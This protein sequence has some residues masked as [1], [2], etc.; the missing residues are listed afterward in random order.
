MKQFS[1]LATVV[2]LMGL[3]AGTR[4]VQAG[5]ITYSF[6]GTASGKVGGVSF[7]DAPL[8]VE[9]FGDTSH[10][11]SP[12]AGF[13]TNHSSSATIS[14]GGF[15]SGAF[16][17]GKLVFVNQNLKKV[18]FSEAL[19]QGF[20]LVDIGASGAGLESYDLKT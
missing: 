16:T 1:R 13:F 19:A 17:F 5:L 14:I 8:D 11:E 9:L 3:L 18:G 4:S 12:A 20:D 6:T 10:V 15:G 7:S 2:V